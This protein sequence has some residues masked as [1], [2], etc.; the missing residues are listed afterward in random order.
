[1]HPGAISNQFEGISEVDSIKHNNQRNTT[2]NI[3]NGGGVF[4]GSNLNQVQPS[5][6]SQSTTKMIASNFRHLQQQ[7]VT[8]KAPRVQ[9]A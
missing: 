6:T 2:T 9:T 4:F 8:R 5:A 3:N 1:M 7:M